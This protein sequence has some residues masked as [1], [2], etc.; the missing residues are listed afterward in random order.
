M[1]PYLVLIQTTADPLNA[2]IDQQEISSLSEAI[3][4]FNNTDTNIYQCDILKYIG[5]K[6]GYITYASTNGIPLPTPL[7]GE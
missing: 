1:S 5:S 3:E 4:I 6:Y 7:P 2:I